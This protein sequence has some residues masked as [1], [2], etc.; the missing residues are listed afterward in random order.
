MMD[1][2]LNIDK[3]KLDNLVGDVM[4]ETVE[5]QFILPKCT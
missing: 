4:D 3:L 5:V 2:A 1:F